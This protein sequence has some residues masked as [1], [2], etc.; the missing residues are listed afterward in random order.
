[1]PVLGGQNQYF[2][3]QGNGGSNSQEGEPLTLLLPRRLWL[4][5]GMSVS[6]SEHSPGKFVRGVITG[7]NSLLT[8]ALI[9]NVHIEIERVYSSDITAWEQ[10]H[11]G[12]VPED[13]HLLGF[14]VHITGAFSDLVAFAAE[15]HAL[16]EKAAIARSNMNRRDPY[17]Q[18]G[19]L[20]ELTEGSVSAL[21]F[22]YDRYVRLTVLIG[23]GGAF[24]LPTGR[25][26]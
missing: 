22:R 3:F 21:H 18:P 7:V 15:L 6:W 4:E 25:S 26:V 5:N 16:I 24:V 17:P 12:I 9:H 23:L 13:E 2:P 8:C 1:M 10:T 11:E 14:Y 20:V 19:S